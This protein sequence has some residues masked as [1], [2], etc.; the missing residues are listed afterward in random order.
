[1]HPLISEGIQK[2]RAIAEQLVRY[3]YEHPEVSGKEI[4][5]SRAIVEALKPFGFAIEYPFMEKEL[6]YGTAFRAVLKR[7]KGPRASLMVEYDALPGVGHGCGHNL[8]GPLS[9]LAGMVMSQLPR[10][11]FQG[12]LELIGTPAEEEDGAKL[13]FAPAGVFDGDDLAVMMHSTSGGI[14]R[15]N[16]Q[17]TALR[18][19]LID[20]KGLTAHA[21]GDPWN[22]HNALTAARKFLDLLD[23]RRDSFRPYTVVSAVILDGGRAPNIIPDFA[24]VRLEFRYPVRRQLQRLDRMIRNCAKGAAL[25]M[26]CDVSFTLGFPDFDDMVRVPAL[27]NRIKAI[28]SD[29]GEPVE[30]PL[31]PAGSTDAGNVSYRC[32]TLHAY[33]SIT[34]E[35]CPG[36]S[37][38]LRDATLT[39]HAMDQMA[40]GAAV[41]CELLLAIY[42]EP[43]FREAVQKDF[44][45][46]LMEKERD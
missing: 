30:G 26:D 8:H 33:I 34:D 31:P 19:Y 5:S 15:T 38:Q 43:D 14:S 13:H 12:T 3:L 21:A 23:A 42:N 37:P 41:L 20:F 25:T 11:A 40:K 16:T 29:Y 35:P 32:P 10:E 17:A 46:A 28:F 1:M 45:E 6:G 44:K 7:G 22:G 24:R 9:V 36:H 18:C 27:E 39:P 2:N 4:L